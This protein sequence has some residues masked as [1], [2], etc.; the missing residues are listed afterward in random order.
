MGIGF[1]ELVIIG[2]ILVVVG[3]IGVATVMLL[4]SSRGRDDRH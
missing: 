4:D 1:F 3:A 2:G